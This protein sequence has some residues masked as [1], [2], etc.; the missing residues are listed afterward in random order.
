MSSVGDVIAVLGLFE[1]VAGSLPE[2]QRR[3]RA[4]PGDHPPSLEPR[5]P[6]WRGSRYPGAYL[7]HCLA[8]PTGVAGFCWKDEG[9]GFEPWGGVGNTKSLR[10]IGQRLHWSMIDAKDIND[11]RQTVLAEM[12]AI[13]ILERLAAISPHTKYGLLLDPDI[14]ISASPSTTY[15]DRLRTRPRR[16]PS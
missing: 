5:P 10:S 8:L 9:H 6:R 15:Q 14:V 11:L 4:H 1:R 16:P 7:D 12:G 2:P 13:T 3:A